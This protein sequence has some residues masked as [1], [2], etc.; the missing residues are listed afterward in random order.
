MENRMHPDMNPNA[1]REIVRKLE[2]GELFAVIA[3]LRADQRAYRMI[4]GYADNHERTGVVVPDE[5][6]G[7]ID[8]A[9]EAANALEDI[10]RNELVRRGVESTYC[11]GVILPA[12]IF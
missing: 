6:R 12:S 10:C 8:G 2:T 9:C 7:C 1:Q 4:A 3:N 5:L 11:R